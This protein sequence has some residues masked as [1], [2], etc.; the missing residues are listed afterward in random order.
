M[1]RTN[2]FPWTIRAAAAIA[3]IG[4]ALLVSACAK[5]TDVPPPSSG[6][7]T[8]AAVPASDPRLQGSF[9]EDRDGW[10]FVHLRGAPGEIGF[11]HGWHLAPEIDDLL[12]TMAFYFQGSLKRDWT[13]FR[14][15]AERM[16]WPK[17]DADLKEEIEGIAEGVRA[18]RPDLAYDRIDIAALNGWIE[19]A[20][21]YV[22]YLEAKARP[23]AG[24]NKAPAYCSA[25]V[26]VGSYTQDGGVVMAHNN[27]CE[28]ILGE[29]WNAIL[30]IVPDRGQR[31]LMDAMPGYVHSGDD[32]VVNG[33][34]LLY[35][36]TTM[37]QFKGFREEGT[38]E[39]ARARRAAQYA[40]S[41]DDFVRIMSADNNGAYANDWL[42]GDLAAGE[43]A[44]L[45]LGLKNQRIWRT[46]D[47]YYVGANFPLDEK[48]IAEETTFDPKNAAQSVCVRRARWEALMAANK[49]TIDA[50][51]AMAFLGDH[52]DAATGAPA[53]NADTL[54]GHADSDAQGLPEFSWPP[55]YPGGA[56][57]GKATSAALARGLK[58]WAR[59][60]HPCGRDFDAAPFAAAHPEWAWQLPYLKD[61]KAYPWALFQGR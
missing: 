4:A 52:I 5:K 12:K 30:D 53:D 13:F 43:I 38:P 1:N 17:L 46:R 16:F 19:L 60:G 15:A 23:G 59:R 33:A 45:E 9:R 24:D 18:R 58:L 7:V 21:Y 14:E 10:M 26:A 56:V 31:I 34:G 47:G 20:W 55:F 40:A 35:T 6:A 8:S 36:E 22:P 3:C 2:R 37:S 57:Q 41:I 39:F 42:V 50:E 11:Q 27:W 54:C 44:R 49:G 48:V 28:Y 32:F 51:K 61:M 25:F 29:R